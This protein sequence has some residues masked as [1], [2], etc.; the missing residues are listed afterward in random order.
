MLTDLLPK[1]LPIGSF[2]HGSQTNGIVWYGKIAGYV[3][4]DLGNDK[5]LLC[6]AIQY[7][8]DPNGD[9]PRKPYRIE[10][11]SRVHNYLPAWTPE[12]KK[13]RLMTTMI[14]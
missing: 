9:P 8:Y 2:C 11:I 3:Q 14:P 12:E 1:L 10:E 7:Y 13:L 4:W 6:Y 5:I